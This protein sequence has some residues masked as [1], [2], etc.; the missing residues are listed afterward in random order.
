ML[1]K[2]TI[3]RILRTNGVKEDAPEEEVR[4]VLL[5]AR[6]HEEDVDVAIAIL[7]ETYVEEQT[8]DEQK[9]DI[10]MG[11]KKLRPE[12]ISSL[13]G[14][15]TVVSMKQHH[16]SNSKFKS[17]TRQVVLIVLIGSVLITAVAVIAIMWHLDMG[18]FHYSMQS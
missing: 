10:I 11:D 18:W 4:D 9:A 7:N 12:T 2:L 13:L 5:A 8:A 14:L 3:K 16:T 6:W 15:E 1:D 17:N